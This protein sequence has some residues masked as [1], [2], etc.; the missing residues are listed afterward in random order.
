MPLLAMWIVSGAGPAFIGLSG[1]AP[2][3]IVTP[4]WGNPLLMAA[5]TVSI[6]VN[7]LV[8]GLI[9]FRIFKVFRQVKPTSEERNL[10]ASGGRALRR[11]IF[12][13]IESGMA[14][15]SIQLVRL[16]LT[17]VTTNAAYN[18]Y[19]FVAGIHGML[20]VIISNHWLL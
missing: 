4:D 12:V 13:L 20:N 9:I 19:P 16:V 14:L 5:L 1:Q 10:G 7:A 15:F 3:D 18:A 2:F 11:V 8:M 6:A 17:P